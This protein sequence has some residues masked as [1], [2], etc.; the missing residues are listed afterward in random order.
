MT[1]ASMDHDRG[2][3]QHVAFHMED[4]TNVIRE[5]DEEEEEGAGERDGDEDQKTPF[6]ANGHTSTKETGAERDQLPFLK[7]RQ[8]RYSVVS[9]QGFVM[10]SRPSF[11]GMSSRPSFGGLSSRPSFQGLS[12]RPSMASLRSTISRVNSE[13]Y[14][15][16]GSFV[17][18][19]LGH[20]F[21][22]I[23]P[24]ARKMYIITQVGPGEVFAYRCELVVKDAIV[25]PG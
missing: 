13:L 20:S 5:E 8:G 21:A 7:A 2:S 17:A 22:D 19:S 25:V 1:A 10:S 24:L 4:V 18:F 16:R 3:T 14:P 12:S 11:G 15:E 6:T 9:A 23:P